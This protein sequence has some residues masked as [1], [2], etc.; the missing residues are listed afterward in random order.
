MSDE[1]DHAPVRLPPPIVG[2]LTILI[3]YG[4]GRLVPLVDGFGFATPARYWIG[5]AIVVVAGYVFG[6]LP[7]KL[8]NQTEQDPKPWTATPEIIVVGPY[9]IT[10]NPMYV[11]MLLVCVGFSIILAEAWILV[12][13]P[14]CGLVIYLTAIRHEEIYLEE[15]FGDSYREY[16]QNV[17]RWI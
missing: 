11:M 12:L 9:K 16:K 17:R 3:G 14:V 5:G 4:L 8:F 6:Y 7:I 1:N 13:T 10:R 2:L 15:K